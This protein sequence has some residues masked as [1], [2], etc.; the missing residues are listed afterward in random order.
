MFGLEFSPE[1]LINELGAGA[2]YFAILWRMLQTIGKRLVS[3]ETQINNGLS[4]EVDKMH[5]QMQDL[6]CI[7]NKKCSTSGDT[8][9]VVK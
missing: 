3:V 8:L 9:E 1:M 4:T 6:E 2:I 5:D 7:K